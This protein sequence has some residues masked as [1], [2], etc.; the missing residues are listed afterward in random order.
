MGQT[1]SEQIFKQTAKYILGMKEEGLVIDPLCILR[2]HAG[3][4]RCGSEKAA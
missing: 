3:W 1:S 4:T 2:G